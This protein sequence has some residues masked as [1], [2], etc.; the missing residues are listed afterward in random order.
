MP[1]TQATM[2]ELMHESRAAI[3]NAFALR[4]ALREYT[5]FAKARY[6]ENKDLQ[7]VLDAIAMMVQMHPEPSDKATYRNEYHYRRVGKNNDKQRLRQEKARRNAGVPTQAESLE[8]FKELN[9]K[10]RDGG[11]NLSPDAY[12]RFNNA[13]PQESQRCKSS[14]GIIFPRDDPDDKPLD[15]E[16]EASDSLFGKD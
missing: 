1:I 5:T 9:A 15:F 8:A 11:I 7:E 3:Q 16:G 13:V 14:S 12:Q 10:R 6:P 4:H 2:I